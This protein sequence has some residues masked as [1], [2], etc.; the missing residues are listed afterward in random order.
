MKKILSY[1]KPYSFGILFCLIFLFIQG[2]CELSL[3]NY[4]SNIVNVGIQQNGI[5]NSAPEAMS[6][7][8]YSFL[9][10]FMTGSEKD[11]FD[12][13]YTLIQSDVKNNNYEDYV[14]KYP[15]LEKEN[16]YVLNTSDINQINIA[17]DSV[18][19]TMINF[20][21]S[22][23]PNYNISYSNSEHI[24]FSQI[25]K[26]KPQLQALPT[27]TFDEIRNNI[28]SANKDLSKQTSLYITKELYSE[29]GMD[30]DKLQNDYIFKIGL[31]MLVFTI[32]SSIAS[33]LVSFIASKIATKTAK[34]LRHDMFR[35][36]ESFS[37]NEFNKFSTASLITRT[38]N[39]ITQIQTTLI[40]SV[41]TLFFAPILAFGG[42]IMAL[43]KSTSMYWTILLGIII[44]I[45]LIASIF[46]VVFPK[47]NLVQ[48]LVDKFNLVTKENLSGIMVIRAFGT[49]KFEEKRFDDA[50]KKLTQTDLFI[51]R[52]MIIMMPA[53]MLL[54]NLISVLIVWTGS[55]QIENSQMQVGDMI[56]FMQ[57]SIQII[58][59]FLLISTMFIMVPRATV[60]A[61]RIAEVLDTE[62]SITDHVNTTTVKKS[63]IKGK[64]EFK[65][66]SFRY[67]DAQ[68]NILENIN[69][70]ALPGQTTAFIGPTGSGK[71]T[72]INLIPRFFDVTSGEIL[73]DGIN[74]KDISQADL[75]DIIGYVPQKGILFS[76]DIESNLKFGDENASQED[77]KLAAD[78]SQAAEFINSNKD[79]FKRK[80]SQ[81]GSNVSGGQ[82]QRLSIARTIL[83]NA[84]IYIFDDSFSALDLK[85]DAALRKALYQ[86]T[87]N[88]TILVVA[89]RI[90]TIMNAEQIVVL[91]DGKIVG[92]GTHQELLQN[93]ETYREIALSQLPKEKIV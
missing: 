5:E 68:E 47:F 57:Y 34:N 56:A 37:N 93:C 71:S 70:T 78:I 73:I 51:N 84:P 31:I 58:M 60:S 28:S 66:V 40:N 89:Q 24:D 36:V 54:M 62:P 8:F 17:F 2:F 29:L 49:Q 91:N 75:H 18:C 4:M 9:E 85:T 65:N 11:I 77:L 69:F 72:L 39:D 79:G 14:K 46:V 63:Q 23:F 42:I 22:H 76:G 55:H 41:R 1:L 7:N 19:L 43:S 45:A 26:L 92:I 32:I 20:F 82:R 12:K 52:I 16:I 10:I 83:K 27:S 61:K 48:K 35:K 81:N 87:K 50:N 86:H 67:A 13:N 53:M 33:M 21:K 6:E 64:V 15:L 90:S 30:S 25:Y 44:L 38:T 3:P 88:S 80:I 74:I 59:A